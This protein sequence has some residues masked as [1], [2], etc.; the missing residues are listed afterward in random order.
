MTHRTLIPTARLRPRGFTLIELLVVV[1]IIALLISILLPALSRARA[2]ARAAVCASNMRQ[3]GQTTHMYVNNNRDTFPMGYV[4][5]NNREGDYD[6]RE[7]PAGAPFGYVHWSYFL[8]YRGQVN[9]EAFHCPEIPNGG[10]VR[11]NPGPEGS[12]EDGIQVDGL[13][14]SGPASAVITD[15]QADRSA[16]VPNGAVIPRNKFSP[17]LQ[18]EGE[19]GPRV[20]KFV[21]LTEV[22]GDRPVIL[23]SE[24]QQEFEYV[25]LNR[26]GLGRESKTHRSIQPWVNIQSGTNEFG[27]PPFDGG[28]LYRDP[29]HPFPDRYGILSLRDLENQGT[30]A[31]FTGGNQREINLIGRHHPGGDEWGGTTDFTFVDGSVQRTTIIRTMRDRWWGDQ[32]YSLKG[33]GTKI[34]VFDD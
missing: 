3:T 16:L 6:I 8:Y 2:Q 32:F 24:W 26:G 11:T 7:Q 29:S 13:G 31:A 19:T 28:W 9:D 34:N 15:F 1:A 27:A 30:K 22:M 20:N 12:W 21:K 10:H 23:Y 17:L 4:Y 25:S 14:A 5:A 33:E 18:S